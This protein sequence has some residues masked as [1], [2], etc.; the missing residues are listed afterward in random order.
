ME[1]IVYSIAFI[2]NDIYHYGMPRKTPLLPIAVRRGLAALGT[3]LQR[4]R[5]RRRLTTTMVAER[6]HITRPTLLRV[7]RGDPA[8]SL[9]VYAT[10]LWVLGFG[11]RISGLAASET[12]TVGLSLED[13]RLP[14]RISSRRP[15]AKRTEGTV[16]E[17]ASDAKAGAKHM[18]EPHE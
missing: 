16:T 9:G 8:V 12:D 3:D 7:E 10:V 14:K 4:A 5:R 17:A 13:E 1:D 11:D 15:R 2:V 6:V 18:D